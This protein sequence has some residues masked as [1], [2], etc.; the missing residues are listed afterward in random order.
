MARA[1]VPASLQD[2]N[3]TST[4]IDLVVAPGRTVV[5]D[6]IP[7]GPGETVTIDTTQGEY[8]RKRGFFRA[9]DGSVTVSASGP[10]V[11]VEDGVRVE[12][13]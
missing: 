3:S 13:A 10:A 12:P 8:L 2:S 1:P 6:D 9:D 7:F 5:V 4:E 11:N